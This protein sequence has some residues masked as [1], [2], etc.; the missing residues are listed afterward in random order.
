MSKN[1][2][3]DDILT[4]DFKLHYKVIAIKTACTGTKN[5]YEDQ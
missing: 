1:S 5:R 3:A 2:N 4:P